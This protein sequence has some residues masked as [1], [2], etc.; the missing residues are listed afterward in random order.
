V[1]DVARTKG[2]FL[3]TVQANNPLDVGDKLS[4][5][6]GDKGVVAKL[7]HDDEDDGEPNDLR[8]VTRIVPDDE[9]PRGEDGRP[10]EV[11]LNPLGII[12]RVNPSQMVEAALGKI[13][14]RTGRKYKVP[15]FGK[16]DDFVAFAQ[17]ELAKNGLSATE[18][19]TDPQTGRK[20]PK[21][22]TGNRFIM[23]LHHT[24]ESKG[25][26]RGTAGYTAEGLPRLLEYHL[27]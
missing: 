10:F 16:V 9:M 20:I 27:R 15:D 3:V 11:L 12:S 22:Y 19:V 5:R 26:G 14:E 17:Q 4:G 23:K 24:A 13:A 18:T 2:G 1:T 21:I 8:E 7:L 6:M 25:Q